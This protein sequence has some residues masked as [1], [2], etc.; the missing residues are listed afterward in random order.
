MAI[1]DLEELLTHLS[2]RPR[3][4]QWC[5]VSGLKVPAGVPVAATIIEDEGITNVMLLSDAERLGVHP[6][7]VAA[8][9][10]LEVHSALE[11]VGLTAAAAAALAPEN[12]SCNVLAGY[13]HDHL[14]VPFDQAERSIGVLD[15]LR[16]SHL[17]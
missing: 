16:E 12:I 6:E 17:A 3:A 2:V 13:Y 5:M 14:L 9:L 8:W 1:R 7:F 4:G 15:A 10:T 11:A